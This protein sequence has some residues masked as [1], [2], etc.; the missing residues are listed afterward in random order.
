[1]KKIFKLILNAVTAPAK[2]E[3]QEI[4]VHNEPS[5]IRNDTMQGRSYTVVPMVM[6]L[7]GVHAGSQGPLFYPAEELAE[8][9]N[10]WNSK[11]VVVYHPEMNG[12]G[13]SA[14]DP[15][16]LT[17]YGIGLIMNTRFE[18]GKLKAEAWIDPEQ[19]NRVDNRIMEAIES[20]KMLELST[21]LYTENEEAEEGAEFNGTPYTYIA[22]NYKPDHLA[23]LPDKIGACSIEKGAGFIRN[24]VKDEL[25]NGV[26]SAIEYKAR[27]LAEPY[28]KNAKS[29]NNI[30]EDLRR[31][32]NERFGTDEDWV[33]IEDVYSNPNFVVFEIEGQTDLLKID[34]NISSDN[35][36]SL[37]GE[38]IVVV[39]VTEYRTPDGAFV[40]NKSDNKQLISIMNKKKLIDALIA[41]AQTKW[42]ESDRKS[43]ESFDEKILENMMP[44]VG[45]TEEEEHE[46][47]DPQTQAPANNAA[48]KKM[49]EK[50]FLQNAPDSFKNLIANAQR[51]EKKERSKNIATIL[52]NE[53]NT[54]TE[55]EL[56][57]W[58][59]ETLEKQA[60]FAANSQKKK[61]EASEE[62]EFLN[63][64]GQGPVLSG[65][66]VEDDEPLGVP[67]IV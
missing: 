56:S 40:G 53:A 57:K 38:A 20:N 16:V 25:P 4:L 2:K 17:N 28:I 33:W 26:V 13:I 8:V 60:L 55:A 1:M 23:I 51:I 64:F 32:L 67:S 43:L 41:N 11:P 54:F 45:N 31:L 59:S 35:E 9:P 37:V 61:E 42:T 39:K 50:E 7:E 49:T 22:R 65:N 52:A 36:V 62:S 14:C 46:E 6:L 34:Y 18:D 3:Y 27:K 30:H 19:A 21:G 5:L 12:Q 10:V 24:A 15:E 48:S 63:Y 29:F 44:V 47:E 58:D 66:S